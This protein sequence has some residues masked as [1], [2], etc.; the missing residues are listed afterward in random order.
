M[1]P[2]EMLTILKSLDE[3]LENAESIH[4]DHRKSLQLLTHEIQKKLAPDTSTDATSSPDTKAAATLS[5]QMKDAV[6]EFE[7]RHP[8]IGGLVERVADGL[9]GMGI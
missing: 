7:V 8:M 2:E 3:E 5:Q 4:P 6:I 1:N 9:S